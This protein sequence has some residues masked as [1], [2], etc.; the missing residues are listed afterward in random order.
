MPLYNFGV[1]RPVAIAVV[2]LKRVLHVQKVALHL[3]EQAV[4]RRVTV[5]VWKAVLN[6]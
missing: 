4:G 3:L 2:T 6:P 5:V 1:H